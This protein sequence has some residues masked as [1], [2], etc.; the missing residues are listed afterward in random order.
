MIKRKGDRRIC[1]WDLLFSVLPFFLALCVLSIPAQASN[2]KVPPEI[3]KSFQQFKEMWFTKLSKHCHFG[4][5]YITVAKE[6]GRYVARYKAISKDVTIRLKH[7]ESKTTPYVAVLKY[8]EDEY[9]S[10]GNSAEKAKQ[11]PFRLNDSRLV[12]EIFPYV[13]GKWRY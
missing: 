6:N 3:Q 1:R 13:H 8:S 4:K 2:G 9:I 10:T 12:T 5:R 11:G 7:T